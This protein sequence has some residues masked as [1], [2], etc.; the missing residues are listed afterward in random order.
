MLF[1]KKDEKSDLYD[2]KEIMDEPLEEVPTAPPLQKQAISHMQ[3]E[4]GA[5]L[6]VKV[7]KYR[8]V[9]TTLQEVKLF[10][11]GVKQLF[12]LVNEIEA[13]RS[14]AVNI[15]RATVDRLEKS[16]VEIDSELLRP[17]GVTMTDY[18]R[19]SSEIGHVEQSL[20]DLQN[21]LAD[22]RRQLQGMR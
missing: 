10:M 9:L 8:E 1:R 11:A 6:F 22:L 5:P 7:D 16:I 12:G 17:R 21:Q 4:L 19:T 18:D 2:I 3:Q 20:T 14:D 13:V 15:M